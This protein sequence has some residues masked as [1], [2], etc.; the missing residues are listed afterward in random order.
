MQTAPRWLYAASIGALMTTGCLRHS[1]LAMQGALPPPPGTT[2]VGVA[3]GAGFTGATDGLVGGQIPAGEANV[4]Y[5][6]SD[7]LGFNLHGSPAGMQPGLE[8]VLLRRG[9]LAIALLPQAAF[10]W[11]TYDDLQVCW[12][13]CTRLRAT[14]TQDASLEFAA[15]TR[16]LI[17]SESWNL[18]AGV[19][20]ERSL[21][22]RGALGQSGAALTVSLGREWKI[23]PR[24]FLRPEFAFAGALETTSAN[25]QILFALTVATRAGGAR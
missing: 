17:S 25:L 3:F 4:A 1:M 15:G 19:D 6:F 11:F 20:L 13:G 12:C 22:V 8:I 21:N 16:L 24:L 2:E 14:V 18:A 10:G 23:S 9:D 7:T 5:G